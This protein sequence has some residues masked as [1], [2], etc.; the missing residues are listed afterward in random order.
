MYKI[1]MDPD[2]NWALRIVQEV[3]SALTPVQELLR[4]CQASFAALVGFYGEQPISANE[5]EFWSG[6]R[7]FLRACGDSQRKLLRESQV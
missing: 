2:I 1:L 7:T 4:S 3:E 5:A 6:I